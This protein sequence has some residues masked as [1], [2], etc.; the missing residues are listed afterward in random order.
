[1][2]S[3]ALLEQLAQPQSARLVDAM[4]SALDDHPLTAAD[5][6]RW[7]KSADAGLVSAAIELVTARAALRGRIASADAFWCDRAGA[8]QASDDLSAQWKAQRAASAV[9]ALHD[10]A[11]RSLAVAAGDASRG[12]CLSGPLLID[13]CCGIGADL[14]HFTLALDGRV[15]GA[16]MRTER[17]W[18]AARNA[19]VHVHVADVRTWRSDAPL[20]HIDP[21]RREESTGARR[22][23]WHAL[24]PG[25]EVLRQLAAHHTGLMVKLGPGT[26]VP[27]EA[28][29]AGSELVVLSRA[30]SLTQA[31]LCTGALA[32]PDPA[33]GRSSH[34]ARAVLLRQGLAPLEFAGPPAWTSGR[35]DS[36]W[37]TAAA[38]S[39]IVAEPDP[40][41]E[42]SGLLSAGAHT[43]GLAEVHPGLGLCTDAPACDLAAVRQSPW[44][45]TWDIVATM[46]ARL[47]DIRTT[48]HEHR[49]GPVDVKVRGG[50]ADA[51]E[52]SRALRGDSGSS[53]TVLVHRTPRGGAEA[54]IARRCLTP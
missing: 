28:R 32:V 53:I 20:A 24:D 36:N 11:T 23:G 49:A 5:V 25:P 48:L 47:D 15:E 44:W 51:D 39:R 1:M 50:V 29:P 37:P 34:A 8:A 52:W 14:A 18:M 45:R 40:S 46:P 6:T 42:R 35:G 33:C 21:S 17:A 2:I 30:G 7:R 31:V 13:Y 3:V 9:A 16:D 41:L 38:W 12:P 54:I 22:H 19:N 26:D 4:A 27:L 43:L 10:R